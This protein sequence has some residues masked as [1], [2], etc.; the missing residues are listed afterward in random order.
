MSR[1][2]RSLLTAATAV[3]LLLCAAT[4]V[5]WV[6]SY[7]R[8][9]V[10]SRLRL[11]AIDGGVR[12]HGLW[13]RSGNGWTISWTSR[14]TLKQPDAPTAFERRLRQSRLRPEWNVQSRPLAESPF[15]LRADAVEFGPFKRQSALRIAPPE[16]RGEVHQLWVA[17]G[18]LALAF[19]ALP[20]LR[21]TRGIRRAV[22]RRRRHCLDCGYDLRATPDRCPECGR[23]IETCVT[24]CPIT[25]PP[26]SGAH[27]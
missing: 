12:E 18:F 14:I 16:Y 7:S 10:C 1:L 21:L 20:V 11:A 24:P 8:A 19:G 13:A 3:S 5:L 23:L 25:S 6:R 15:Q 2:P 17:H 27:S 26:P 22:R 9:D 4:V